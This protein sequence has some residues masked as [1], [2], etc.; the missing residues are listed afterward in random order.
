MLRKQGSE[1]ALLMALIYVHLDFFF[2]FVFVVF[3]EQDDLCL[4]VSGENEN[5]SHYR[6]KDS[7]NGG[8]G[9][10]SCASIVTSRSE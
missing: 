7:K 9:L 1:F 2:F 6:K 4:G 8:G 3:S 5:R 10:P